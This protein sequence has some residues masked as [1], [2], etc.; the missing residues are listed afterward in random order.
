MNVAWTAPSLAQPVLN[1]TLIG[2]PVSFSASMYLRHR[3]YKRGKAGGSIYVM[4]RDEITKR[5]G[6][7]VNP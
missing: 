7:W 4:V 5:N 3:V 1:P 2:F 6:A